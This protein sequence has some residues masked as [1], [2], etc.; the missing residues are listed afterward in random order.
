MFLP[1]DDKALLRTVLVVD[2]TRENLTVIGQLLRPYYHL[3]VANSGQQAMQAAHTQPVPDIILLDVMMPEMDGYEV[4]AALRAAPETREIPVIF[5]TALDAIADEERG[6]QAGAVDYVAK[7]IKPA[8]LLARVRTHLE[9]EAARD[10][11]ADHNS[12]L[13]AEVQRRMAEN[14]LIKDFSLHAMATLAE[15]RDN[16]TGNHL[17]RT[18]AYIEALM[19]HLQDHPRFQHLL[20]SPHQ[21]QQIAKAAPL[22]DIGRWAF[23]M[24]SCSSQGS[25]PL[26]SSRS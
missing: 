11:L 8:V 5:V 23:R 17:H 22:H 4:L 14:E 9:L 18:Q 15:K 7:P 20:G 1:T 12:Y 24:R 2:D 25:S 6:L 10:W 3:R 19:Q 21:R 16:E 26:M 13:D